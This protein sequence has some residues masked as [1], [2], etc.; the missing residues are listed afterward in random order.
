MT[1]HELFQRPVATI[2]D[3]AWRVTLAERGR[4]LFLYLSNNIVIT[5]L[6]DFY[7]TLENASHTSYETED[8]RF[9]S[10]SFHWSTEDMD[11]NLEQISTAQFWMIYKLAEEATRRG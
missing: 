1:S 11:D 6:Q 4:T 9:H 8:M 5:P 10:G 3:T 7:T 2:R